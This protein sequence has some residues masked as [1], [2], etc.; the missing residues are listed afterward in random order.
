MVRVIV[1][2]L[3]LF[4]ASVSN[5]ETIKKISTSWTSDGSGAATSTVSFAGTILRV[6]TNPGSAA[7]TD[8][9]DVT[10]LD[11]DGLD[12]FMGRGAN[13]DTTNSEHFNPGMST[14]DGTTTTVIPVSFT[15]SATLTIA[16]A[17]AAKTGTVVIYYA[18][19]DL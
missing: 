5:A 1:F 3:C 7:P 15:G 9:W 11:S 14:T 2:L 6:V 8:D 4:I 10:L 16:N 17:G 12:L 13:R 18:V 19:S